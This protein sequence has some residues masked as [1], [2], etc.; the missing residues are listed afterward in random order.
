MQYANICWAHSSL[1]LR[2]PGGEVDGTNADMCCCP[3]AVQSGA[4]ASSLEGRENCHV[5]EV[6]VAGWPFLAMFT[7]AEVAPGGHDT[8]ALPWPGWRAG[9]TALRLHLHL[10]PVVACQ[11]SLPCCRLFC[12]ALLACLP[13]QLRTLGTR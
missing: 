4:S 10:G 7:N 6:L 9:W 3:S 2:C 8:V 12:L 11:V 5:Y 1:T 13:A